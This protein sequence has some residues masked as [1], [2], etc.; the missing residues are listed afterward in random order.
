[1]ELIKRLEPEWVKS[2]T[3]KE[4]WRYYG[5]FKCTS[6]GE[7][8]KRDFNTGKKTDICQS[9]WTRNKREKQSRQLVGRKVGRLF[10]MGVALPIGKTQKYL[11]V[12]ECGKHLKVIGTSLLSGQTRSCGCYK[13]DRV[14]ETKTKH[15]DAKDRK[16][17]YKNRS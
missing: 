14:S 5:L 11:C 10:V 2:R 7:I 12:C 16:F 1:M 4:G 17:I 3:G 8:V 6:C 9:C 13:W 15:G